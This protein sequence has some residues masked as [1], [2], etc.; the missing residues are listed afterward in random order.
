ML[1]IILTTIMYLL[2]WTCWLYWTHRL[3]HIIPGIRQI[4]NHHHR[5]ISTHT[6]P[7]WSWNNLLL[8]NDN[9]MSTLDWWFT[10]VIPT[11][12]FCLITGQWWIAVFHYVYSATAQEQTEHNPNF[13]WYPWLSA[14]KWHLHHHLNDATKNFGPFIVIW[15]KVFGTATR[16]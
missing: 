8:F 3:G 6:P 2:L 13:S 16:V 14:G 7:Q 4:H 15:D 9:W 1:M 11:V 12:I 5:Y 10:E